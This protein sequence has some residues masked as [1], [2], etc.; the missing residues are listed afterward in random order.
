[1]IH[2]PLYT[3]K[4]WG[5]GHPGIF[6]AQTLED[7]QSLPGPYSVREVAKRHPLGYPIVGY[8]DDQ[9]KLWDVVVFLG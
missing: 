6:N 5:E 9:A 2:P 8:Y 3:W 4:D 7:L 1:M